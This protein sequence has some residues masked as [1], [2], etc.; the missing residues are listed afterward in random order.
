MNAIGKS[1]VPS[2]SVCQSHTQKQLD[3]QVASEHEYAGVFKY[4]GD[5]AMS[6]P[7]SKERC[8]IS[9][10]QDLLYHGLRS[11]QGRT[12]FAGCCQVSGQI[13]LWVSR[14]EGELAAVGTGW[15]KS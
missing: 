14:Y 10:R 9:A 4:A 6:I 3:A 2:V 11:T 5:R 8:S 1:V 12:A 7:E 13:C 15:S